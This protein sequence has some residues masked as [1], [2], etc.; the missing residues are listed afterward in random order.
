MVTGLHL[1][2][3]RSAAHFGLCTEPEAIVLCIR[4][5]MSTAASAVLLQG[6]SLRWALS[7]S[8]RHHLIDPMGLTCEHTTI[9]RYTLICLALLLRVCALATHK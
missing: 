2:F 3:V 7:R 6:S 1:S 4:T 9:S 5:A 8:H